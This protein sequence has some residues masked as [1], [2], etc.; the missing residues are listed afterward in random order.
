MTF[1][2]PLFVLS[3]IFNFLRAVFFVAEKA[4]K[5]IF[6]GKFH[7]KKVVFSIQSVRSKS[8]KKLSGFGYLAEGSLLCPCIS[9]NNK[10]YIRVFDDVVN[11]CKP[12]KDR[13]NEFQGYVTINTEEPAAIVTYTNTATDL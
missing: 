6:G 2:F 13:H 4:K 7:M 10:P 8:D 3:R 11:R 5:I 12:M 9:K 1:A